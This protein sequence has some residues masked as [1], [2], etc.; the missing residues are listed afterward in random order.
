MGDVSSATRGGI[1]IGGGFLPWTSSSSSPSSPS[2]PPLSSRPTVG[3]AACPAHP[4][5]PTPSST[6]TP[7][8]PDTTSPSCAEPWPR[9]LGSIRGTGQH[10][11]GG[12]GSSSGPDPGL[13]GW[14]RG[15][16]VPGSVRAS[17]QFLG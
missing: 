17:R 16:P 9:Q 11:N 3:P 8:E 5:E 2:S 10:Q 12:G 13:G 1:L 14:S 15:G 6:A 4:S 7:L